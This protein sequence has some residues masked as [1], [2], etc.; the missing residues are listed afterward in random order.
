[1]AVL[2]SG[3]LAALRDG[4]MR[5][6]AATADVVVLAREHPDESFVIAAAR[7]DYDGVSVPVALLP[8]PWAAAEALR[9]GLPGATAVSEGG[10][11]MLSGE[12]PGVQVWRLP[13]AGPQG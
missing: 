5:W 9:L 6:L 10:S 11:L 3:G 12:G 1:M 8:G 13:G 2:A 4:A 7:A